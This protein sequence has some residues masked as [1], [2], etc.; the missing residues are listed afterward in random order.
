MKS[1]NIVEAT[2]PDEKPVPRSVEFCSIKSQIV[3]EILIRLEI[4]DREKDKKQK[5][6]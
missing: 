5:K 4:E 6:K 3:D 1:V 2:L